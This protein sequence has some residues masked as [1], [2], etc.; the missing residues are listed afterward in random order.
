M[1]RHD[2]N[3]NKQEG[4]NDRKP[5]GQKT[6]EKGYHNEIK[7]TQLLFVRNCNCVEIN[8]RQNIILLRSDSSALRAFLQL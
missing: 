7:S 1:T 6:F 4:K 8:V 5:C 3:R 2:E